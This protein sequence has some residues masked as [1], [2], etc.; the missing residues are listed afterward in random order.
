MANREH[1]AIV[2]KGKGA[3]AEWRQDN[4]KAILDLSNANLRDIDLRE[5]NLA[6]AYL[7]GLTLS[8]TYPQRGSDLRSI[9]LG[10]AD[11]RGANLRMGDLT[12]AKLQKAD[13]SSSQ[14]SVVDLSHADLRGAKLNGCYLIGSNLHSAQLGG[15]DFEHAVVGHTQFVNLDL[16]VVAGLETVRHSFPSFVD[17]NTLFQSK[18]HI[19]ATF[20]QG[21]GIPDILLTYLPEI[22]SGVQPVQFFSCFISY[23]S[24]D[25]EFAKRLY[26]RMRDE[27]L[28][29]WFAPEDLKA[30]QK[31]HDQI[32]RAI[33]IHDRLLL[34]LSEH[35]M[36]SEWVTTEIRK[37]RKVEIEEKR[38]KL[39]P[40]RLVDFQ[41]IRRWKCFDADSG[42]DL[43]VEAR[44]YFMP[45]FSNWKNND[46]FE[47]S[48]NRLLRDLKA[49]ETSEGYL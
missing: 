22:I 6:G 20:L 12:G 44:E 40:I 28:R 49:E 15:A 8:A 14:L 10:R 30:G 16:S 26:S 4:P 21:C 13:L 35:S 41:T 7:Q 45:D 24:R 46:V 19:P 5:A 42:K 32:E 33:Q 47:Q 48:F 1:I 39:F 37:A 9:K 17:V 2:S 29:V 27:H 25:E 36:Q 3:I 34:I 31:L 38:R 23:S 18:G 11:L 43:A